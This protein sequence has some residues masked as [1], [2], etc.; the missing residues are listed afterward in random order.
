MMSSL[1]LLFR[2]AYF[3]AF[4]DTVEF[5]RFLGASDFLSVSLTHWPLKVHFGAD[6]FFL[7]FTVVQFWMT[8]FFTECLASLLATNSLFAALVFPRSGHFDCT[9]GENL[10]C[11]A[12]RV[13]RMSRYKHLFSFNK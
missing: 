13:H 10:L 9:F 7:V 6:T 11:F 4:G 8:V 2:R 3:F 12:F 5:Y 1:S